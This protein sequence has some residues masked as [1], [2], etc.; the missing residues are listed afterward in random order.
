MSNT[1]PPPH[2][3]VS[4]GL[5]IA[6]DTWLSGVM[7]CNVRRVSGTVEEG[8]EKQAEA[9]LRSLTVNPGFAYARVP[10]HE[11]RTSRLLEHA[12][13]RIVDTGVTL[14]LSDMRSSQAPHATARLARPGDRPDVEAVARLSFKY[15]RFHLDPDIPASMANEIKAQWVG[16]YFLG[17]RGDYMVVAEQGGRVVG[18]AQLLN[19][20]N[21]TLVIDLIAVSGD[22]RGRGLAQDMIR[23]AS[24]NCGHPRVVRAGTQIANTISLGLY[25]KM[26]F[27]IV[28]SN[29]VFHYHH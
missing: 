6:E 5:S 7:R 23:F 19:A 4:G 1:F 29:Y 21:D 15:S 22:H 20:P 17:Q 27:R 12:G 9:E 18:F 11:M 10:T 16:N 26:G 8:G 24:A 3:R 13:F 14:E 28:S 25:R 2:Q